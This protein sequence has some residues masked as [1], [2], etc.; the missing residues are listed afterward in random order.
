MAILG[1]VRLGPYQRVGPAEVPTRSVFSFKSAFTTTG[2]DV[3]IGNLGG[4]V[5][6]SLKASAAATYHIDSDSAEDDPD[7][8]V[9]AGTGA[10]T[11]RVWGI[12]LSDGCVAYEDC[13]LNGTAAVTI[14][15]TDWYTFFYMEVLTAGTGGAA[16]GQVWIANAADNA[17]YC[18]IAANARTSDILR[19]NIPTPSSTVKRTRWYYKM[20][21][22]ETIATTDY[23]ATEF[24]HTATRNGT[25]GAFI[26]LSS[27]V[28][29]GGIKLGSVSTSWEGFL[30]TGA[31]NNFY[32][33]E[34]GTSHQTFHY[35]FELGVT[36][37]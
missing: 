37:E 5:L 10:W 21:V 26:E 24:Y 18:I 14:V 17:F 11:V 16:A 12:R 29:A 1:P 3:L 33:T 6:T 36:Y 22:W 7:D 34:I 25:G 13:T 30:L 27:H 4:K 28:N 35:T 31:S 32:N 2:A 8:G 19:F 9:D 23:D 15:S 20:T